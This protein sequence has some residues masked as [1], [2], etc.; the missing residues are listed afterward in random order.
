MTELLN[1]KRDAEDRYRAVFEGAN[2]AIALLDF[3][4]VVLE[5]NRRW[6]DAL[7]LCP[8]QVV[9]R[10]F[11]EFAAV[12]YEFENA[13]VFRNLLANGEEPTVA[14]FLRADGF[15]VPMEFSGHVVQVDGKQVVFAIGHEVTDCVRAALALKAAEVKYRALLE[16]IPEVIWRM[17]Q[18]GKVTYLTA[19]EERLRALGV[20]CSSDTCLTRI[21]EQVHPE[22]RALVLDACAALLRDGTKFDLEYRRKNGDGRFIWIRNRAFASYE[23]DGVRYAEG[24]IS[25]VTEKKQ[26]EE[27]LR[28]AQ[29]M[30]AIGQLT[31]GIA[32]DFNNML[33]AIL[34]NGHFLAESLGRDDPRRCDAEEIQIVAE[35][36][37][38]LT[39]QLLAFSRRQLLAPTSLDLN[40]SL[41]ALEKMLR[42]LIGE[43]IDLSLIRGPDL[44]AIRADA[45][46]IEQVIMNLVVNARDAMPSGGALT[47]ETRNVELGSPTRLPLVPGKY[48]VCSVRDTGVGMDSDTKLRLFEPFFTTKERGRGTGLGL[49]TCYG[50]V[51]QSGGWIDVQ[52]ELGEGAVF[53]VYL[54]A[55]DGPIDQKRTPSAPPKRGQVETILVVEDDSRVRSAV[56]RVLEGLG[57]SVLVARDGPEAIELARRHDGPLHL[58]VSD[59]VMPSKSGVDVAKQVLAHRPETKVLLMSGYAD[60]ASLL[61]VAPAHFMQKPFSPSALAKKVRE[62]LDA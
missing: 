37:A 17:D 18:N 30:E 55:V 10:R 62:V 12:G 7:R 48:V 2:D 31:G 60:H 41:I 9:G 54:P 5:A 29:K 58:V 49:S 11:D 61:D 3:D 34:A 28:Q 16:R 45:G 40:A 32:H 53:D 15:P 51:T 39:R 4:G 22:Q 21:G 35:R 42:R 59:L 25:D 46:Q 14:T 13:Q 33:V 47:I 52:S 19:D 8:E 50:I 27:Q 56:S 43:D 24:M 57:Y 1:E 23:R 20:G 44:R 6:T 38:A 26:L 36:A